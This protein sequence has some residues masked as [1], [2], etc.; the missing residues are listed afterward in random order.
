MPKFEFNNYKGIKHA[1]MNL[2]TKFHDEKLYLEVTWSNGQLRCLPVKG[3]RDQ[4]PN[5]TLSFE[6]QITKGI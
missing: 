4:I 2:E 3:S 5:Q 6:E 1:A